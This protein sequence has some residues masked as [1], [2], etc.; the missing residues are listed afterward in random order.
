MLRSGRPMSEDLEGQNWLA[1]E[2]NQFHTRPPLA[3][4]LA[5]DPSRMHHRL[6]EGIGM[7]CFV[8]RWVPHELTNSL[9]QHRRVVTCSELVQKSRREVSQISNEQQREMRR[10]F[11][12]TIHQITRGLCVLRM[13]PKRS[14]RRLPA[15]GICSLISG[16]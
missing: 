11:I 1:L 4:L 2:D 3:E 8:C 15:R 5:V 6:T 12:L 9:R 10:G 7:K 16:A 14:I 13:F